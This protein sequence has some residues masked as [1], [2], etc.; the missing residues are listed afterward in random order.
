MCFA[1]KNCFLQCKDFLK[2]TLS[3]CASVCSGFSISTKF[4]SLQNLRNLL[5]EK[6]GKLLENGESVIVNDWQK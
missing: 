5:H 4:T 2:P 3:V 1:K 6:E